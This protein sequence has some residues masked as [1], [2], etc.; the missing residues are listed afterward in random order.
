MGSRYCRATRGACS[1]REDGRGA[2]DA[3]GHVVHRDGDAHE[4]RK[5]EVRERRHRDRD[6]L[7][8]VV[9]RHRREH[10]E[11]EPMQRERY[12]VSKRTLGAEHPST[13]IALGNSC[14]SLDKL[15]RTAEAESPG[16]EV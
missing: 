14:A 13:L 6:A 3:L 1:G 11:A 9:E 12:E 2:H 5:V 16:R 15:G 10:H 7:G 4:R 8:Q